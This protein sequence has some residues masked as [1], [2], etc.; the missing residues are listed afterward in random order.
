MMQVEILT[1]FLSYLVLRVISPQ[2]LDSVHIYASYLFELVI[3]IWAIVRMSSKSEFRFKLSPRITGLT[4]ILILAGWCAHLGA[5]TIGLV[6]PFDATSFET[7]MF[8]LVVAPI[9]EEL[10]FRQTFWKQ[11]E[12]LRLP[13][14]SAW[15]FTSV[16]FSFAHLNAIRFVPTELFTFI[17]Y[18]AGYTLLLG[19]A[20]GWVRQKDD[21]VVSAILLHAG[22]N[23]GFFL[24][25]TT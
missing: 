21:S 5:A 17:Y 1:V 13:K 14:A 18:Q 6:I 7:R 15:I 11:F 19:L 8:L 23:L 9:L 16:F 24:G 3:V 22:F 12:L 25:M 2:Y 20:C 10:L 4:V